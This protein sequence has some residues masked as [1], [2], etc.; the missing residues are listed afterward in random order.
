MVI[1]IV[2]VVLL[3]CA[4]GLAV[5]EPANTRDAAPTVDRRLTVVI[6]A[7]T[8]T[9]TSSP[10][11]IS[12]PQT[13]SALFVQNT[14]VTLTATGTSG[15]RFDEWS[16]SSG[17]TIQPDVP[18]QCRVTMSSDTTVRV[19]FRPAATLRVFPNGNGTITV[20]P[21]GLDL[22]TGSPL[23]TCEPTRED[24]CALAYLPGTRVTATAAP[25]SGRTFA[26]WSAAG[27]TSGP[28]TVEAIEGET[29]LVATFNPLQ[30]VVVVASDGQGVVTSSP[31][32]ITC[33]KDRFDC[34]ADAPLGKKYVLDAGT[35]PHEWRF[36]CEP[37]GG[38]VHARRCTATV[39]ASPTQ[40]GIS[41][42]GA[43]GP[44]PPNRITIRLDVT[45]SASSASVRGLKINCGATCTA[46]YKFGDMEQLTP[47]DGRGAVFVQWI[48]GCGTTRVCR[49]PVGPITSMQAV[50]GPPFAASI[51]R[52]RVDAQRRVVARIQVNRAASV[53]LRLSRN[54]RRVARTDVAVKTG[55][56]PVRVKLP[57]GASGR[58]GVVAIVKSGS[59]QR[60]LVRSIT[61]RR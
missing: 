11:G 27:C 49:F 1:P 39:A 7:G 44:E 22:A 8:G 37:E 61:V 51:V 24:G 34:A 50:F 41:F 5:P 32:G 59:A 60:T 45:K 14:S 46:T 28:C 21:A 13:C 38:D 16:T 54:G 25:G 57:R 4:G 36:G 52:L 23:T 58:F 18:N 3:A 6:Q 31:A 12:C 17:C 33:G 48:N 42:N 26:G 35:T 43:G 53:S 19:T 15:F 56:T 55:Q 2:A 40:A 10:G 30:L 9:V 29:S 20:S 47:V